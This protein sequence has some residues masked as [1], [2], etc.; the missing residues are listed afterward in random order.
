MKDRRIRKNVGIK[1]EQVTEQKLPRFYY[2]YNVILLIIGL[3]YSRQMSARIGR[4][5]LWSLLL[6]WIQFCLFKLQSME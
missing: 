3:Y 2:H 1:N 6:E 4:G 5:C